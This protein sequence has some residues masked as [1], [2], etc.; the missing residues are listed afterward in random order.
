MRRA[1]LALA[2]YATLHAGPGF[3][4][5]QEL[6]IDLGS[7]AATLD[8]HLQW[9]TD[10][11]SV[12]RNIFDNLVTRDGA[13]KIVPQVAAAW[14]YTDDKTLV[15]DLR[16]DIRFQDGTKLTPDD[17]AFSVQ[18]I[19]NPA[20]KSPQLSQ[21]DQ[22]ASAEVTGPAQVTLHTKSAYPALLAQLV[23]LSIVP[24]AYVEKVG[25]Q[26]FNLKPI[27]SGPYKLRSWQRGVSVTLDANAS[28]WR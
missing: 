10:S 13:G 15:F 19:I 20:F 2:F 25:D 11:Y 14:H 4:Q 26:E 17:V 8:P 1:I 24:K 18:R 5:K 6:T 9:D 12:Y 7:D 22:I 28:Y 21:F 23:K 3:A 27:G 16:N